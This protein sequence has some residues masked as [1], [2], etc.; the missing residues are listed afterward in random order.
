MFLNDNITLLY[1]S[2]AIVIPL[3]VVIRILAA[4]PGKSRLH[5]ASTLMKIT[6]CT[7][8]LYSVVV[9]LILD[10]KLV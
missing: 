5:K 7:G 10:L 9:K 4:S 3:I 1:I 6:Q 2:L 8:V